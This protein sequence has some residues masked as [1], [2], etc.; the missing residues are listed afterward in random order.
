MILGMGGK[1]GSW[2]TQN[3]KN[4]FDFLYKKNIEIIK[5]SKNVFRHPEFSPSSSWSSDRWRRPCS[6]AK[7]ALGWYLLSSLRNRVETSLPNLVPREFWTCYHGETSPFSSGPA[8][9]Q[10]RR[11]MMVQGCSR[12]VHRWFIDGWLI[13]TQWKHDIYIY[14]YVDFV[15]PWFEQQSWNPSSCSSNGT[16]KILTGIK[17]T[18]KLSQLKRHNCHQVPLLVALN[19]NEFVRKWSVLNSSCCS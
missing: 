7:S 6:A 8:A 4:I 16:L 11:L 2:A 1:K 3:T 18:V 10:K 19:A 13:V 14:I 9:R 12:M 5:R 15:I 17:P